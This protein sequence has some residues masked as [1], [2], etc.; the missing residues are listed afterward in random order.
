MQVA[1]GPSCLAWKYLCDSQHG[2]RCRRNGARSR[3]QA[4]GAKIT[5]DAVTG[6]VPWAG[7]AGKTLDAVIRLAQAS[8]T[9][10]VDVRALPPTSHGLLE[11]GPT[12]H[13]APVVDVLRPR[14]SGSLQESLVYIN[15]T[16]RTLDTYLTADVFAPTL[17]AVAPVA[18]P[19][20]ACCRQS[21]GTSLHR[22]H[23]SA[24]A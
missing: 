10:A 11:E 15:Q 19:D 3:E 23:L 17:D 4:G 21:Q 6:P 18:L 22:L 9:L 13:T 14:A 5:P 12:W 16:L 7:Y 20:P 2:I 1:H 24:S 8:P